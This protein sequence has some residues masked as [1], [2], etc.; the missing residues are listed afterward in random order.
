MHHHPPLSI[1]STVIRFIHRHP[2][3]LTS[4]T[5]PVITRFIHHHHSPSSTSLTV[6]HHHPPLLSYLW[7]PIAFSSSFWPHPSHRWLSVSLRPGPSPWQQHIPL[8]FLVSR[9]KNR[10]YCW[11]PRWQDS[12]LSSPGRRIDGSHGNGC[13]GER[14]GS[15][16]SGWECVDGG[17][18]VP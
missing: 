3:H 11:C 5:S 18:G 6:I 8:P 13:V 9:F 14:E 4:S 12:H 1:S 15:H 7:F 17:G 10:L 16:S 2:H